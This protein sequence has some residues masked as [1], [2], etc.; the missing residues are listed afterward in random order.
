MVGTGIGDKENKYVDK[1]GL[2]Y[3]L[4]RRRSQRA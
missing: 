3:E 2:F 4:A 1:T